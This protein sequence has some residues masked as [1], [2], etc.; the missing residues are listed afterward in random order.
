MGVDGLEANK[1]CE[2]KK[3]ENDYVY[4]LEDWHE[5]KDSFGVFSAAQNGFYLFERFEN[6]GEIIEADSVISFIK[7]DDVRI[8]VQTKNAFFDALYSAKKGSRVQ[9][10]Y[11]TFNG[12]SYE[13]GEMPV[14]FTI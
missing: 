8:D 6:D 13:S 2:L 14:V 1:I 11:K 3:E 10:Y 4:Y 9:V 12:I 7:I 5:L